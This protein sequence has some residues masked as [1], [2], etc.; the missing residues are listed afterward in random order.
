[1]E[2]VELGLP[3]FAVFTFRGASDVRVRL[4]AEDEQAVVW[5]RV[6]SPCWAS[7]TSSTLV[8]GECL[9]VAYWNLR[10]APSRQWLSE[11][12]T[13]RKLERRPP[14]RGS[15]W[16]PEFDE[17]DVFTRA[18]RWLQERLEL[19]CDFP[20]D[21]RRLTAERLAAHA[22]RSAG[23]FA[24]Q[25]CPRAERQLALRFPSHLRINV[26]HHVLGDRSGRLGQLVNVEPGAFLFAQALLSI[27][28][29]ELN[30]AHGRRLLDAVVDGVRLNRAIDYALDGWASGASCRAESLPQEHPCRPAWAR[31]ASASNEERGRLLRDQRLLIRRARWGVHPMFLWFPAPLAF[32]PEDIPATPTK[33]ALWFENMI[34]GGPV[35]EES[36]YELREARS[37]SAFLSKNALL[38]E[39][40]GVGKHRMW[41]YA[42]H[43]RW[44]PTRSTSLRRFA[45]EATEWWD[46]EIRPF[47][48]DAE[49][50]PGT[51]LPQIAGDW[52]QPD[53]SIHPLRTVADVVNEGREMRHCLATRVWDAHR[54]ESFFFSAVVGSERLTVEVRRWGATFGLA[55]LAGVRNREPTEPARGAIAEWVTRLNVDFERIT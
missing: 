43:S 34:D 32:A 36:E 1:M 3:G 46:F 18:W 11:D 40:A 47:A 6:R 33:N 8:E 25:A 49:L 13:Q 2:V 51:P 27:P 17:G 5:V 30:A 29:D 54:G 44:F 39:S 48:D 38:L 12:R 45:R 16:E 15:C 31:L 52:V 20:I 7:F 41:S 4:V 42:R 19:C 14:G 10:A 26:L 28:P 9:D 37:F 50:Q 53:C 55:G 23:K 35:F 24:V 22:F 21:Q